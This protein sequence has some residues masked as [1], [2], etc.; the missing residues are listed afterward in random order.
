MIML[1]ERNQ[2]QRAAYVMVLYD[3]LEKTKL[4]TEK[5]DQQLP[6]TEWCE[7]GIDC[8]GAQGTFWGQRRWS[9]S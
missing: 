3:I 9:V 5:T 1:S 4:E 7:D 2:T 8:K 6:A